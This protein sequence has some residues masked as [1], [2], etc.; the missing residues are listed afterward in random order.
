MIY[1]LSVTLEVIRIK[2]RALDARVATDRRT[3]RGCHSFVVTER[4]ISRPPQ[5]NQH[6][7]VMKNHL[8]FMQTSK[9]TVEAFVREGPR[10]G[11][12]VVGLP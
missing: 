10:Q 9:E 7:Y 6:T 12:D 4:F 5:D 2:H 1:K 11:K 3:Q 8:V